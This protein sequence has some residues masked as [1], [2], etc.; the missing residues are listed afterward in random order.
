MNGAVREL[1]LDCVS[2]WIVV[3]HSWNFCSICWLQMLLLIIIHNCKNSLKW[4]GNAKPS[5]KW[6]EKLFSYV[7]KTLKFDR[8]T[9][10]LIIKGCQLFFFV[11][12]WGRQDWKQE[13]RVHHPFCSKKDFVMSKETWGKC[14]N[15]IIFFK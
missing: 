13:K 11:I 10:R 8:L 15:C 1:S 6:V 12:Q 3:C 14:T 2:W 5:S 4:A 9:G 7:I